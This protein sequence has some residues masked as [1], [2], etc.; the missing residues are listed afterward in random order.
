MKVGGWVALW[1]KLADDDVWLSEPFTRG[2]AWVDLIMLARFEPGVSIQ[3]G[4]SIELDRGELAWSEKALVARW[5]RSRGWVR[6]VLAALVLA[7]QIE[8][9]KSNVTSITRIVNYDLYQSP[10]T[11]GGTSVGTAVGTANGTRNNNLTIQ[12]GKQVDG[13]QGDQAREFSEEEITEV[14]RRSEEILATLKLK[15]RSTADRETLSKWVILADT[16]GQVW[17]ASAV[18]GTRLKIESGTCGNPWGYLTDILKNDARGPGANYAQ[19][20]RCVILPEPLKHPPGWR[21]DPAPRL[22]SSMAATQPP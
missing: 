20:M 9:R 12:Q 10:G 7:Q 11:A 21:E 14:H 22:C 4:L 2:Q 6:R 5:R 15:C 17:L 16:I 18:E 13:R 19:K 8:Q 3:K 1:R